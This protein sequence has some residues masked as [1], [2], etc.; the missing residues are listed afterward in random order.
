MA[1]LNSMDLLD[2]AS[3]LTDDEVLVRDTVARFVSDRVLPIIRECFEEHRF[4]SELIPEMANL[5]LF[6]STLHGYG[7]AGLNSICY[8]L[9]CQE[10][11]RG[12]SGLR[13]FISVQSSLTM[14]PI[15]RYGS[16]RQ[17]E[18]WLPAM[19]RGEA[20]GCFGLTEAHGGSDPGN[21]KT[22]A[23]RDGDD[24]ILNGSKM[25]ITN[26]TIADVALVWA[27]TDEGIRGFLVE[28]GMR[29]F[30][31]TDI[32]QKF[33]M[34]ASIT[35]AL[36]FDNVRVPAENVLPEA[37][38]L[39]YPL[40]CLTQAR[41]GICW[42]VI[43]AAQA[44]LQEMLEYADS[45]VLFDRPLSHTQSIQI[46][47][48]EMARRITT[49]QLLAF[50]LAQL[51]DAGQLRPAQVSL[52]KWHNVRAALEIARD[53]RDMLGGSGISV[54]FTPMRHML[55]LET[56]ITYEGTETVHQLIVGQA[57]T[58]VNAF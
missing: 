5:G 55:N 4:P 26:G 33:S 24:W 7:W 43:G 44:C 48:A 37:V 38:G 22:H 46:R 23:R 6:G 10:L 39:R 49:S 20:L 12:D 17:K 29:G 34:R 28:R 50:R 45:R 15:H 2:V 35:S 31:A 19:A 11:E 21:M 41:F 40:S 8:G 27:M 9:I 1:G 57:L 13:S 18:R 14:Y 47:L 56:V 53:G 52:T 58:S 42:G 51:K 32:E 54:E 16:D 30:E 25:W 36:F 3:L